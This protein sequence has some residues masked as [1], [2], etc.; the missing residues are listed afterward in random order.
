MLADITDKVEEYS[1]EIEPLR[2]YAYKRGLNGEYEPS[3][4]WQSN[5]FTIGIPIKSATGETIQKKSN[6]F[7]YSL[8][9]VLEEALNKLK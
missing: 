1:A 9:D 7:T 3:T 8:G 6:T 4:T 5:N 2:S